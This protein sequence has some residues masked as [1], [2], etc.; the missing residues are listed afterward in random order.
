MNKHILTSL[1]ED[2]KVLEPKPEKEHQRLFQRKETSVS[3]QITPIQSTKTPTVRSTST[4]PAL[5]SMNDSSRKQGNYMQATSS[6]AKKKSEAAKQ[7]LEFKQK[8]IEEQK[9][10]LDAQGFTTAAS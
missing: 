3:K 5:S 2:G 9:T 6:W 7:Q 4:K 1:K 10:I 8:K